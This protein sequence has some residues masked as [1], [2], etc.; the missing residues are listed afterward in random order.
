MTRTVP[1][2]AVLIATTLGLIAAAAGPAAAGLNLGNHC[3]PPVR[4]VTTR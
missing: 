4:P 2:A 3:E 1:R